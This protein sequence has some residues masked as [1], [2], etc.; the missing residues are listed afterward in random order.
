MRLPQAC[1]TA[2]PGD[3]HKRIVLVLAQESSLLDQAFCLCEFVAL[4]QER[5]QTHKQPITFCPLAPA[6][7]PHLQ[8]FAVQPGGFTQL[9]LAHPHLR[10]IDRRNIV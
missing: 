5:S 2:L 7:C 10:Q 8:P 1:E 9:A 3:D 4:V 6:L